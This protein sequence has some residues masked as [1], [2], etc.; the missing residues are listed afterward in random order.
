MNRFPPA[1]RAEMH[2]QRIVATGEF[3]NLVCRHR[4][5]S[6]ILNVAFAVIVEETFDHGTGF[7]IPDIFR[8]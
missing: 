4:D 7:D 2:R 1:G 8:C 3:D 6:G 5:R